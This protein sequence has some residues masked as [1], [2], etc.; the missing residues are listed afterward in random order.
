MDQYFSW[1]YW[2]PPR[3]LF[4]IPYIDHPV[5]WYGLLFASGVVVAYLIIINILTKLFHDQPNLQIASIRS[6]PSLGKALLSA[7]ENPEHPLATIASQFNQKELSHNVYTTQY[8]EKVLLALNN[9][10]R[11]RIKEW[12]Y[13]PRD[14]AFY[15]T[16]RLSWFV[17]L[18]TIIGARLG[19]VFFYEWQFYMTHP[20]QIFKVWEGGLASHG[21]TIGI[22]LSLL[23]FRLY[24]RK[25]LP[26][27]TYL[28]LTDLLTIPS[29]F[30]GFCIRI[31]NFINQEIVGT[32]TTVPW[33]IIF[34]HPADGTAGLPRHPVQLYE[35]CTYLLIF[36]LLIALWRRR[37]F[38]PKGFFT[39]LFLT[40]VFGMRFILESF[41][42]DLG[43][44][45]P[46]PYLATGQILSVPFVIFGISLLLLSFRNKNKS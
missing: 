10:P 38:A 31:G 21:G 18:G 24:Y 34:A 36:L 4:R 12:V 3:E 37:G 40:L 16:D 28:G 1:I 23:A 30:V 17:I 29:A 35:G 33:A 43:G 25:L 13:S 19:H 41:K 46:I 27:L 14:L 7:K 9:L 2:D 42:E 26:E 44:I 11:E 20:V 5:V 39:G 22:L 6:W 8:K 32:V 15:F 45:S